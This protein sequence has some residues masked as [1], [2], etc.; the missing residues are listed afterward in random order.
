MVNPFHPSVCLQ[1]KPSACA[2]RCQEGFEDF[3]EAAELNESGR[4][5]RI[6]RA[7][8]WWMGTLIVP[9]RNTPHKRAEKPITTATRRV[10]N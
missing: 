9:T 10:R 2:V 8:V 3:E 1:C 4:S 5:K 7:Q 6:C